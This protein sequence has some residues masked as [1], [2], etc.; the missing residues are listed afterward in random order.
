[1][2][3]ILSLLFATFVYATS[4]AQVP[5]VMNYQVM[6]L[7]PETGNVKSNKEV[8]VKIELRKGNENGA[9]VWSQEFNTTTGKG[10]ICNLTLDFKGFDWEGGPF[11][12]ATI[13]D[14]TECG[15]SKVNSIPYA[16]K[17]ASVEGVMTK[18]ILVGRWEGVTN[19]GKK[20]HY[21]FNEDGTGSYSDD[22]ES[23]TFNYYLS[24]TGLLAIE[25]PVGLQKDGMGIMN[26]IVLDSNKIIMGQS[27][28]IL[29]TKAAAT[30]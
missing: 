3:K 6:V 11:F 28:G 8:V 4:F 21:S 17:A 2:R 20:E 1:M 14:G 16:M 15:A 26:I 9:C 30:R 24:N 18:N 29:F 27:Y 25:Y 19:W 10:G 5:E 13:I 22:Y 23:Y 12:I 7:D